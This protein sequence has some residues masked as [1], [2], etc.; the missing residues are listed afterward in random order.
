MFYNKHAT[1]N[2][3]WKT[4]WTPIQPFRNLEIHELLKL[5]E[6]VYVHVHFLERSSILSIRFSK[7]SGTLKK[8]M[9]YDSSQNQD[10]YSIPPFVFIIILSRNILLLIS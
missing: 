10:S 2:Q 9:N 1:V 4:G 7:E 3:V 5:D 6:N 8:V